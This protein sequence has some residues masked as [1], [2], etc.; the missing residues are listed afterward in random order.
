MNTKFLHELIDFKDLIEITA[1]AES[2]KDP[3]ARKA[4]KIDRVVRSGIRT[5]GSLWDNVRIHDFF[6]IG[7]QRPIG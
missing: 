2:I 4:R 7:T 1:S 5:N 3:A 6:Q